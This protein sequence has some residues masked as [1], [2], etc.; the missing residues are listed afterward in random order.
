M[1]YSDDPRAS[2]IKMEINMTWV[3]MHFN[4]LGKTLEFQGDEYY[5]QG[6]EDRLGWAI[7]KKVKDYIQ[8]EIFWRL[9][10][11]TQEYAHFSSVWELIEDVVYEFAK[12]YPDRLWIKKEDE[13]GNECSYCDEQSVGNY[14]EE[15][16]LMCKEHRD[17][18]N[19]CG[20]CGDKKPDD[21]ECE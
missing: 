11:A 4:D 2:Y 17:L 14:G 12:K 16:T 5:K 20:F 18:G 10:E 3:E 21:C 15:N 9:E 7:E 8:R 13:V 19:Y 6:A 1:P